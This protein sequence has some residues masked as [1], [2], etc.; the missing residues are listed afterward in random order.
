LQF[1]SQDL[2]VL[3][4]GSAWDGINVKVLTEIK[5]MNS[6]SCRWVFRM[7]WKRWTKLNSNLRVILQFSICHR[8]T[9]GKTLSTGNNCS[10]AFP[11]HNFNFIAQF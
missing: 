11:V 9:D 6:R 3:R 5:S 10:V 7:T 1:E 2:T 4:L 8:I